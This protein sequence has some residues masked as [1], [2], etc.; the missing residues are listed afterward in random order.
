[1][2]WNEKS[3]KSCGV[4]LKCTATS[5]VFFL[6]II[7]DLRLQNLTLKSVVVEPMYFLTQ[8]QIN[9]VLRISGKSRL[10]LVTL[11]C[12]KTLKGV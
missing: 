2:H 12:L 9:N 5:Q 3:L 7:A 4:L 8:S 10:Y 11:A 1:M 6:V